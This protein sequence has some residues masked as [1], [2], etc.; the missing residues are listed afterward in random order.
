MT[1]ARVAADWA[2]ISKEPGAGIGYS[3]LATSSDDINFG[4][5]IGRY[6]PG[7][8]SSTVPQDAPDAPPWVTFGPVATGP[9]EILMTVSVW[10]SAQRRDHEWRAVWPQKLF[11]IRFAELANADASYRTISD[12]VFGTV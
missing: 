8:P 3:V 2:W 4:S 7:S 6:V 11:V 12:A 1:H 9:G 5:F 10:D